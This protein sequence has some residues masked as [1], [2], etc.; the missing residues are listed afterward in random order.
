MVKPFT[1]VVMDRLFVLVCKTNFQLK[2]LWLGLWAKLNAV[3]F[4]VQQKFKIK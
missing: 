1:D 4:K 3:K 2:L